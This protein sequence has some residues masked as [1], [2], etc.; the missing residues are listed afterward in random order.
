[1][2]PL[3]K[4]NSIPIK[5]FKQLAQLS[6][7]ADQLYL[8]SIETSGVLDYQNKRGGG[9]KKVQQE[10]TFVNSVVTG[11]RKWLGD[12]VPTGSHCEL[13]KEYAFLPGEGN[14]VP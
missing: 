6:V 10:Q 1:M 3:P 12:Y 2:L 14:A 7:L 11:K 9:G 8:I 4:S 5:L 13:R